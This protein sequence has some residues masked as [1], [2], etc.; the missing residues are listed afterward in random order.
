[1]PAPLKKIGK[2]K[3]DLEAELWFVEGRLDKYC[4]NR[5]LVDT[6]SDIKAVKS[7][8]TKSITTPTPSM[9]KPTRREEHFKA[10]ADYRR[11]LKECLT[12]VYQEMLEESFQFPIRL[13]RDKDFDHK[14]DWRY[15]LY[16]GHI[17]RFDQA[18][19]T[20]EEMVGRIV[21]LESPTQK[22]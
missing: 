6:R 7:K 17:Y 20:D 5:R 9:R 1:M 16:Q 18:G 13:R 8:Y 22:E 11:E 2:A 4:F 12:K 3:I 19:Y 21:S 15:C 10:R 14:S